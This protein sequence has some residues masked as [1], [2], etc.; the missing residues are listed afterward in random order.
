[1]WRQKKASGVEIVYLKGS[2]ANQQRR[3][4]ENSC[5]SRLLEY[6][7]NLYSDKK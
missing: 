4:D 3:S 7:R 5:K 1:M 6:S 2:L